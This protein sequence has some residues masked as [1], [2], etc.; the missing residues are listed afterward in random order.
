M[1]QIKGMQLGAML[2]AM[3]P[4]SIAIVPVVSAQQINL[5]KRFD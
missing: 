2:A 5:N 3:L 4:L 1:K